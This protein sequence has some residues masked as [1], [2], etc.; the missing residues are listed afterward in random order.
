MPASSVLLN[1]SPPR[2]DI[3]TLDSR[4]NCPE[5]IRSMV[6]GQDGVG[7][8]KRELLSLVGNQTKAAETT[9]HHEKEQLDGKF[10][11]D[12]RTVSSNSKEWTSHTR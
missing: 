3:I 12:L 6:H 8:N 9:Y 10:L 4:R 7:L 2:L 11:R 1:A 5:V